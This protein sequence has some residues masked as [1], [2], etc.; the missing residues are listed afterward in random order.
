MGGIIGGLCAL[1][2]ASLLIGRFYR[3]KA[4]NSDE[5]PGM[6]D[7]ETVAQTIAPQDTNDTL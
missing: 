3:R 1:I 6:D 5:K 4:G 2:L 7:A